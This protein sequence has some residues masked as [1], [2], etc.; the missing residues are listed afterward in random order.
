MLRPVA[1]GDQ[2]SVVLVKGWLETVRARVAERA[3]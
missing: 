1:G 3:R 2:P